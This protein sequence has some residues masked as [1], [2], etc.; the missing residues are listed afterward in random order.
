VVSI[1]DLG[2]GLNETRIST[3]S[4]VDLR[5]LYSFANYKGREVSV[6]RKIEDINPGER[7]GG[8]EGHS[9]R[10]LDMHFYGYLYPMRCLQG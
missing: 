6:W 10:V 7:G 5:Q 9:V 3:L 2:S 8:E 1:P 4:S